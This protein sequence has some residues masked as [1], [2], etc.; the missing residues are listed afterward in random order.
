MIIRSRGGDRQVRT[1]FVAQDTTPPGR[2]TYAA[3]V[4]VSSRS[5]VGLPAARAALRLASEAVAKLRLGVYRGQGVNRTEVTTT[6]QARLFAGVPNMIDSW[7]LLLEQT[8]ASLTG[9]NN[10]L[11][12]KQGGPQGVERVY[13]VPAGAYAARWDEPTNRPVY[14]VMLPWAPWRKSGWL[15]SD[16]VLHFRVGHIEPGCVVAPTPVELHRDPL[17]AAIARNRYEASLYERGVTHSLAVTFPREVTVEAARRYREALESEHGGLQGAHGI[18]TFG[19]GASVST[20]G[21]TLQ[22]AQYIDSQRFT[23]EEIARIFGVPVSLIGGGS[24][25]STDAP[26]SPEHEEDRWLRYGLGPRLER[27]EQTIRAD[28]SFFGPRS[29]D[30]PMFDTSAVLRG[31]L[32]TEATVDKELVQSG[33]LLPDEARAKRGL[34]PLPGGAGKIPQVTPVGGAPNPDPVPAPAGDTPEPPEPAEED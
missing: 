18:R 31:D 32:Q 27:I 28:E 14:Q 8:E 19:G 24:A 2:V 22:D 12:L 15:T 3:G 5:I 25:Q 10:A 16:D 9:S 29:R 1:G 21:L 17:G 34:P 7:F 11:W 6:W 33:I 4:G 13:F 23:I 30:Y 26:I 20:V